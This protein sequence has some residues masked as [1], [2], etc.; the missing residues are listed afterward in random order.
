VEVSSPNLSSFAPEHLADAL[1]SAMAALDA[2]PE[3]TYEGSAAAKGGPFAP[4]VRERREQGAKY[5]LSL[6]ADLIAN[7]QAC[8][9]RNLTADEPAKANDRLFVTA[10]GIADDLRTTTR[11]AGKRLFGQGPAMDPGPLGSYARSSMEPSDLESEFLKAATAL[12]N[13]VARSF[14][15]QR[16]GSRDD[17]LNALDILSGLEQRVRSLH[18]GDLA[19]AGLTGVDLKA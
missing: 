12:V 9:K 7:V 19:S 18:P 10:I 2:S 14:H 1:A 11:V 4:T 13:E 6:L 15:E 16:V 3:A 8:V 17:E 5:V